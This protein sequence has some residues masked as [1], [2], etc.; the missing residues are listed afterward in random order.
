MEAEA[1]R[2]AAEEVLRYEMGLAQLAACRAKEESPLLGISETD[3]Y[4][5]NWLLMTPNELVLSRM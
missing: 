3:C 4:A 2:K 5:V 1:S